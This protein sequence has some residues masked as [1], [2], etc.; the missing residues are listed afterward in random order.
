MNQQHRLT[1]ATLLLGSQST[2]QRSGLEM[3]TSDFEHERFGWIKRVLCRRSS[4]QQ[5]GRGWGAAC[6][7]QGCCWQAASAEEEAAWLQ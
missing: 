3:E 6:R 2:L 7:L 1:A 4:D 5:V